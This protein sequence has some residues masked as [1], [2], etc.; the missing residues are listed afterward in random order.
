MNLKDSGKALMSIHDDFFQLDRQEKRARIDLEFE[1]P[2]EIFS[3]AVQSGIPVMSEEFLARIINTFDYIPDRY[4]LD[5]SVFF[6]DLEGYTE[7]RLE[8]I[9]WKNMILSLRIM[10]RKAHRRNRLVLILCMIGLAF[11]LL[12]T[13]LNRVWTE[14]GTAKDIA[15]FVMNIVATVPFWGAM[16]IYLVKGSERRRTAAGIRKRFHSIS[17]QRK[18]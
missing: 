11:I 2:S 3:P 8:E 14:E 15:F 1:S 17:F 10:V 5:I 18:S 9:F 7:E 4:K 16:D 12:A 6:R 13:W